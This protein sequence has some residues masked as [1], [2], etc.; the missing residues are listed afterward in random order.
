MAVTNRAEK[1]GINA[2]MKKKVRVIKYFSESMQL[3]QIRSNP[4]GYKTNKPNKDK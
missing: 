3:L 4:L 1:S 2:D